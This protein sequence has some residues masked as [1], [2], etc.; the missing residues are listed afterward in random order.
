VII[1]PDVVIDACM[2]LIDIAEHCPRKSN[3][4]KRLDDAILGI[5]GSTYI[6]QGMCGAEN[7]H[8]ELRCCGY[9]WYGQYIIEK[10]TPSGICLYIIRKYRMRTE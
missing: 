10:E 7:R 2:E 8:S 6:V 1:C 5:S 9:E 3:L 4:R